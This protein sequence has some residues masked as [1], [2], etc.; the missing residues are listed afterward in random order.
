MELR[1]H[2]SHRTS[3]Q[4]GR[5]QPE[6][7]D[8]ERAYRGCDRPGR[9]GAARTRR[10]A[11]PPQASGTGVSMTQTISA[12]APDQS[13]A[14]PPQPGQQPGPQ[15]AQ[16]STAHANWRWPDPPRGIPAR[17]PGLSVRDLLGPG[18]PGAVQRLRDP[19]GRAGPAD[20][21]ACRDHA[22]R[23]GGHLEHPGDRHQEHDRRRGHVAGEPR[24]RARCTSATRRCLA[25]RASPRSSASARRSEHRSA[26]LASCTAATR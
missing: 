4:C 26:G 1:A 21:A 23:G 16:Q 9:C 15:A 17:I 18:G 20:S 6:Q 10:L 8:A 19:A 11:A 2:R 24:A 7:A 22:R 13:P 5:E 3:S 12:S 14:T 25:R